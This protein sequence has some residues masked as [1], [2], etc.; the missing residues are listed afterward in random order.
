MSGRVHL[1]AGYHGTVRHGRCLFCRGPYESV[2]SGWLLRGRGLPEGQ[3]CLWCAE[4]GPGRA[5][6]HLRRRAARSRRLAERCRPCLWAWGWTGL[7]RLLH[8]Y[9]GALDDLADRLA[10]RDVW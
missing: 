10:G 1:V 9:A 2:G 5:A 8:E 4:A 3:V 7:H 6:L